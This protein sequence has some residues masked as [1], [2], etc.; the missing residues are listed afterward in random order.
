MNIHPTVVIG[1]NVVIGKGV[2]IGPY[3]VIGDN[4]TIGEGT[5]IYNHCSIGTEAQSI[6]SLPDEDAGVLIGKN[7]IIREFVT[8]NNNLVAGKRTELG[9]AC[10]LME[11]THVGHDSVLKNN[12]VLSA[13]AKLSGHTTI[14]SYTYLGLNACT[15]QFSKIGSYCMIGAM[16]FFKGESPDAIT[17]AGVPAIPKKVNAVGLERNVSDEQDIR[18]IKEA[19]TDFIANWS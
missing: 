2:T 14:G 8:I 6:I 10:Y 12:V 18:R 1:D 13:G 11:K 4:V 5:T 3:T 15:H 19:A 17:W 7:C 9:D 16:A